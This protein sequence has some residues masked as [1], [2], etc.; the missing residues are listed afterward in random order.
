MSSVKVRDVEKG[1]QR[2]VLAEIPSDGEIVV[3]SINRGQPLVLSHASSPVAKAIGEIADI[4]VTEN[5]DE[6]GKVEKG[7][8]GILGGIFGKR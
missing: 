6:E 8:R 1:L 5:E 2:K 4:I 7:S 3:G